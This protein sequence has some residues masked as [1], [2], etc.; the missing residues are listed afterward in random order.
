MAANT[1]SKEDK[2]Q[3]PILFVDMSVWGGDSLAGSPQQLLNLN[4]ADNN[5][6][7]SFKCVASCCAWDS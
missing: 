6:N 3:H 4:F 7:I 2:K 5:I 1:L